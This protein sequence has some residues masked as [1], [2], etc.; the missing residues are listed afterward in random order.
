MEYSEANHPKEPWKQAAN[1]HA[2]SQDLL[3]GHTFSTPCFEP[4]GFNHDAPKVWHD[5]LVTSGR[6]SAF[7]RLEIATASWWN[8]YIWAHQSANGSLE[9]QRTPYPQLPIRMI[10]EWFENQIFQTS[11]AKKNMLQTKQCTVSCFLECGPQR[12][13]AILMHAKHV[14]VISHDNGWFTLQCPIRPHFSN[15]PMCHYCAMVIHLCHMEHIR[16]IFRGTCDTWSTFAWQMQH[17][18]QLLLFGT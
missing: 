5:Q 17:L 8:Q 3:Y 14:D 2:P 6:A 15:C 11:Y 1:L 10:N 9:C 18:E 7:T 4:N 16:R 12:S 13:C